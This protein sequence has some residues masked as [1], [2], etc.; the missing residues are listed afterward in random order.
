MPLAVQQPLGHELAS[1]TQAPVAVL[2]SWPIAHALQ[3]APLAPHEPLLSPD[4]GSHVEPEQQPAHELPPHVHMPSSQS[5]PLAHEE[6][7]APPVP[8]AP[9]LCAA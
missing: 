8:H 4:S 5:S 1:Q 2:H 9:L 7:A 3:L 6:Q